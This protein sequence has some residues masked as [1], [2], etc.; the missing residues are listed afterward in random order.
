MIIDTAILVLIGAFIGWHV[1]QP[2][3]AKWVS[4]KVAELYAKVKAKF[5]S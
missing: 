1:P 4:A 2:V 3:W 5:T